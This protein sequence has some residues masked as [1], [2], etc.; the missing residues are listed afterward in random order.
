MASGIALEAGKVVIVQ[1]QIFYL[2]TEINVVARLGKLRKNTSEVPQENMDAIVVPIVEAGEYFMVSMLVA[3][4]YPKL[5][6]IDVGT[7]AGLLYHDISNKKR[8]EPIALN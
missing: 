5:R 2:G 8:P 3:L 4:G 1:S 7:R 6:R